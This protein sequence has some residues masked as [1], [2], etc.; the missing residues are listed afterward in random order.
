MNDFYAVWGFW[1]TVIGIALGIAG[2]VY[3]VWARSHP[4]VGQLACLLT[5]SSLVPAE[6]TA[7][8]MSVVYNGDEVL[9]PWITTVEVTNLGPIDLGP[10]AFEGGRLRF[11]ATGPG[12]IEGNL[13]S[14]P[15]RRYFNAE[16]VADK[17]LESH[18][19]VSSCQLKVGESLTLTLL[20]SGQPNIKV[21]AKLTGF[22]IKLPLEEAAQRAE[23]LRRFSKKL[24]TSIFLAVRP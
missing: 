22:G 21:D 23:L 24:G 10:S 12:F 5:E 17:H 1:I 18:F 15:G 7:G 14:V 19:E 6:V 13:T 9:Q 11:A 8:G 2:I 3:G 20:S 4:R 16:D